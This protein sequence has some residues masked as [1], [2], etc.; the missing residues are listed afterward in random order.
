M[1][2]VAGS[3]ISERCH[4]HVQ[5]FLLQAFPDRRPRS[6]YL[7][8]LLNAP[9]RL[10]PAGHAELGPQ[11][12]GGSRGLQGPLR[13]RE[14]QL[15]QQHRCPQGHD[16]LSGRVECGADLLFLCER[17]QRIGCIQR[18]FQ[19]SDLRDS[20]CQRRPDRPC[21]AERPRGRHGR[22]LGGVHHLRDR[23]QRGHDR[24]LVRLGQR[25]EL[26]LGR[27]GKILCLGGPGLLRRQGAGPRQQGC[28][29]GVVG[30]KGGH[31]QPEPGADGVGGRKPDRERRRGR[32][33]GRGCIRP[34]TARSPDT[35]G[36]RP[37]G[38]P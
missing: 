5:T 19:R 13:D 33:V 4:D 17:L 12:R 37:A 25:R 3:T 23:P 7:I 34:G 22:K 6:H 38:P 36:A 27:G 16:V 9:P 21:G 26:R 32:R 35:S 8:E 24:V 30:R 11:R 10:G 14:R 29:V 2:A 1:P 20:G 15:H 18:V 28:G 31:G